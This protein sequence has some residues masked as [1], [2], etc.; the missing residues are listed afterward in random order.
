MLLRGILH[1]PD[2][3][4]ALGVCVL[5]LSPGIKGRVGPHRLYL[6][7]AARLAPLGFHVLRFDYHGLGD[8]EGEIS[9][10]VLVDMYNTIHGGRYTGD[11]V[12]AMDWMQETVWHSALRRFRLVRWF[13]QRTAHCGAGFTDRVP[14]GDRLADRAGR[15][16]G[17]LGAF[18]DQRTVGESASRLYAESARFSFMAAAAVRQDELRGSLAVI[19]QGPARSPPQASLAQPHPRQTTRIPALPRPFVGS[20]SPPDRCC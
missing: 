2:A 7:I 14:A 20:S 4:V 16:S 8:S 10:L 11:T 12:A 15:R 9:E 6:K 17:Q 19:A 13:D 5:L 18:T 1:E 3:S